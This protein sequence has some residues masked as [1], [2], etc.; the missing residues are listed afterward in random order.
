MFNEDRHL[1]YDDLV[2]EMAVVLEKRR[3]DVIRKDLEASLKLATGIAYSVAKICLRVQNVVF[4]T[5]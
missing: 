3:K 4:R 5:S 1:V 2:M